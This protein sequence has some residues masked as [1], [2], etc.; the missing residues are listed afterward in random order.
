MLYSKAA[1]ACGKL[2][3]VANAVSMQLGNK[4]KSDANSKWTGMKKRDRLLAIQG[5]YK[6][7]VE[8]PKEG[9]HGFDALAKVGGICCDCTA[10]E[11]AFCKT[12][13]GDDSGSNLPMVAWFEKGKSVGIESIRESPRELMEFAFSHLG[14]M[15]S[16][17]E[18]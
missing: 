14:F 5:H 18:L 4:A 9:P 1:P 11:E 2:L 17:E 13:L 8:L 3:G 10:D 12:V 7:D 16:R 15:R 6:F